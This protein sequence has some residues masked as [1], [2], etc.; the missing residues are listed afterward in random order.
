LASESSSQRSAAGRRLALLRLAACAFIGLLAV[1]PAP[2]LAQA[3]GSETDPGPL[4]RAYP[5][6]PPVDRAG[7]PKEPSRSTARSDRT[8]GEEGQ[9]RERSSPGQR[10]TEGAAEQ[11]RSPAGLIALAG[12]LLALAAAGIGSYYRHRRAHRARPAPTREAKGANRADERVGAKATDSAGDPRRSS[13]TRHRVTQP[14]HEMYVVGRSADPDIGEFTGR[15]HSIVMEDDAEG[16]P[17]GRAVEYLVLDRTRWIVFWAREAEI[18]RISD[19]EDEG[20][21]GDSFQRSNGEAPGVAG[22]YPVGRGDSE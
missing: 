6:D 2:G 18:V 19:A 1:G 14:D 20:R 17:G 7:G 22:E 13:F 9:G 5:L 10:S 3:P 11:R 21:T 15:V 4:W 12:T 16:P 8:G